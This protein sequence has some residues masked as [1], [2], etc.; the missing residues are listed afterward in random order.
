MAS[1]NYSDLCRE[2][3]LKLTKGF[4]RGKSKEQFA[5]RAM[6]KGV[7]SRDRLQRVYESLRAEDAIPQTDN[8]QPGVQEFVKLVEDKKLHDFLAVLMCAKCSLNAAKAFVKKVVLGAETQVQEAPRETPYLLP[9]TEEY[10]NNLFGDPNDANDFFN[11]QRPFCAIVV[12]GPDVVTICNEDQRMLPWLSEKYIRS[13]SFGAVSKVEVAEGHLTKDRDFNQTN[14]HPEV[15]ARKDFIYADTAEASFQKEWGAIKDIFNSRRTHGNIVKS[16]GTIV[17]EGKPSTFSLLMPLASMDLEEYMQQYPEAM[18]NDRVARR[19]LIKAVM[20]LTDGLDFLHSG[21]KTEDGGE[22]LICYHMDLKPRNILVFN[23]GPGM[24]WKL[25]DFGLSRVKPKVKQGISDLSRLFKKRGSDQHSKATATASRRGEGTY[26][27]KE[28][29]DNGKSMNEKSDIWS[30]GCIIS[31]LFTFMEEGFRGIQPFS[32]LRWKYS[33]TIF[34]VFYQRNKANLTFTINKGVTKQ[35]AKLIEAA[36]K[37][38][39]AEGE[40]L[41]FILE[42]LEREVLV[43]DQNRRCVAAKVFERLKRTFEKYNDLGNGYLPQSS[44]RGHLIPEIPKKI[45]RFLKLGGIQR[46][47][48]SATQIDVCQWRLGID[49]D[50]RFKGSD[51]SPDAK[52]AINPRPQAARPVSILAENH[53]DA[54]ICLLEQ[55]ICDLRWSAVQIEHVALQTR[56]EVYI[57]VRRPSDLSLHLF[58]VEPPGA[59]KQD[60]NLQAGRDNGERLFTD[61]VCFPNADDS[62]KTDVIVVAQRELFFY[63]KFDGARKDPKVIRHPPVQHY[64]ILKIARN[65]PGSIVALGTHS[66]SSNVL[67]LEVKLKGED[68]RPHV[69]KLAELDGVSTTHQLKLS[70]FRG[71]SGFIAQVTSATPEGQYQVYRLDLSGVLDA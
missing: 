33:N 31:L 34:D 46:S 59:L 29:Q 39:A 1:P 14:A 26:Q 50:M 17:I 57:V 48:R 65:T 66:G 25:S 24:S 12:G 67:L 71:G 58:M 4:E 70:L 45:E 69:Q 37:R 19:R 3:R 42:W 49:K 55:T 5:T 32:D 62:R 60:L 9:A 52:V 41:S 27:P 40:A 22:S 53:T 13:G 43:I 16:F 18:G 2:I 51:S 21:L 47:R 10:L 54:G 15:I 20:G 44:P 38:I 8:S 56:N 7:M 68:I 6:V 61:M 35:H 63:L 11:E 28:A 64:W 36:K 30:L 23:V